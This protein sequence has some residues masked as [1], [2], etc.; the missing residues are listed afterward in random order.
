[1]RRLA[2]SPDADFFA[3]ALTCRRLNAA[4][5]PRARFCYACG[6]P[7]QERLVEAGLPPRAVCTACA[8]VSYRNPRIVVSAIVAAAGRVLLCRRAQPPAIGC[9]ALP[10][11]FLECGESL[12]QAAA[13]E[14]W[15]ETG[16]RVEPA[17]MRLLALST[18]P[19]LEEVHVGFRAE[20][21]QMPV[22][23]CGPECSEAG[24]FAEADV[25]WP[26]LAYAEIGTYLRT[27][28]D[29]RRRGAYAVH[30]SCLTPAGVIGQRYPIA[31]EEDVRIMRPTGWSAWGSGGGG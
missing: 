26:Q 10:G 11:G 13:R 17:A 22:P 5:T 28:F 7:L 2:Q 16:V 15:E 29:E 14:T 9:W 27:Y 8:T 6:A 19:D 4:M 23:A 20:L 3:P 12:E 18:L 25:P 30:L 1:M 31:G 24:F 21:A